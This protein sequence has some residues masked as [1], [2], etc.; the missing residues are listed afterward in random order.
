MGDKYERDIEG[1]V[2]V[3]MRAIWFC[4]EGVEDSQRSEA[5]KICDIVSD[6]ATLR[7][8]FFSKIFVKELT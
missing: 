1:A 7:E 6:Y 5:E 4:P 8:L 2:A 3:G